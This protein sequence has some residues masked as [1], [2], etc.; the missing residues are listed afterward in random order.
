[1]KPRQG[2]VTGPPESRILGRVRAATRAV[3]LASHGVVVAVVEHYLDGAYP[4]ALEPW[5]GDLGLAL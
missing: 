3:R 2:K 1:M 4:A 5:D